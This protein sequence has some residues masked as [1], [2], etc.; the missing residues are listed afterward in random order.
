MESVA[1]HHKPMI[2]KWNISFQWL[3]PIAI[4]WDALMEFQSQMGLVTDNDMPHTQLQ[5]CILR[6][7]KYT[8]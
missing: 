3:P 8:E 5:G 6:K 1:L 4:L 7:R 2:V